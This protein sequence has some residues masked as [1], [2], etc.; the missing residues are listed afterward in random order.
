M[1]NGFSGKNE[2][3]I[4]DL[5]AVVNNYKTTNLKDDALFQLGTTYTALKE[6]DKAHET[7]ERLLK[8]HSKSS[9]NPSVLLRQGLLFYNQD[10][11]EKA[12][13]KFKTIVSKYPDT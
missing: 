11:D 5:L 3:K 8:N 6:H 12:L 4:K 1:S 13:N 7:Y 10:Q 2:E 9:Y